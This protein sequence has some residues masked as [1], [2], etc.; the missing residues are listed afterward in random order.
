[1]VSGP[2]NSFSTAGAACFISGA[3]RGPILSVGCGRWQVGQLD[4]LLRPPP[5]GQ[6]G[7]AGRLAD[8]S[9]RTEQ[10]ALPRSQDSVSAVVSSLR[11]C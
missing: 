7:T 9:R 10:G 8:G 5:G 4:P 11:S 6:H 3:R 1:M 2:P